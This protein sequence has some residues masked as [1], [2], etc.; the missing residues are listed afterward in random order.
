MDSTRSKR[1]SNKRIL[2]QLGDFDQDIIFGNAAS[3]SQ[4]NTVVNDCTKDRY[5][6]IDSSSS[7]IAI[8]ESTV[9]VKTL[10]RCFNERI[11]REMSNIVDTV[12]HRIQNAIL[13]A[14]DNIAV[15][16]IELAIRPI[17]GSSGRDV[18]SVTANSERGEHVGFNTCFENASGNN[19]RVH[20][21]NVNDEIRRGKWVVGPRKTFWRASTHSL[22]RLPTGGYKT[23]ASSILSENAFHKM[24]PIVLDHNGWISACCFREEYF[25]ISRST[26]VLP[27]SSNW[28]F[29]KSPMECFTTEKMLWKEFLQ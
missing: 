25:W 17:N 8:N 15:P 18:T 29:F 6:T 7:N 10:E 9:N 20:V 22:Q 1:Q 12:E 24:S 5:L 2:S 28:W 14:I 27:N 21:S 3:E 16:K 13:T 23:H 4:G 11:G 26:V 19:N